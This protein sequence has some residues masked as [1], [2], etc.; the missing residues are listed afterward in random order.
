MKGGTLNW[1]LI[2]VKPRTPTRISST[3]GRSFAKEEWMSSEE[4]E[5]NGL[6]NSK[7]SLDEEEIVDFFH[8]L[9]EAV[10]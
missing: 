7:P 6:L 10:H 8:S 3:L 1:E 2:S 4:R 9:N 5:R